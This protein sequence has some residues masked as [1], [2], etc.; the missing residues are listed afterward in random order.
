MAA[1]EMPVTIPQDQ[2]QVEQEL[3]DVLT[4]AVVVAVVVFLLQDPQVV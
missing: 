3:Q 2:L 1:V 4:L